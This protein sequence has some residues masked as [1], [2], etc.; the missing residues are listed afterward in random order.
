MKTLRYILFLGMVIFLGVN[1]VQALGGLEPFNGSY[2]VWKDSTYNYRCDVYAGSLSCKLSCINSED[3][4][5][6]A[7]VASN[8]NLSNEFKKNDFY[9]IV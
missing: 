8:S 5:C 3:K 2:C 1:N 9:V 6:N 7:V 4:A